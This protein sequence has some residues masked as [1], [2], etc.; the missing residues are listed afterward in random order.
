[1]KAEN[2]TEADAHRRLQQMSMSKNTSLRK[3]AEATI[4]MLE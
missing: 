4:L 1:M 2:L 3:V